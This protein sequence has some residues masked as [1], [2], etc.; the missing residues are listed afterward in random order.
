[1]IPNT[2][3]NKSQVQLDTNIHNEYPLSR[4]FIRRRINAHF[5]PGSGTPFKSLIS[6]RFYINKLFP[7]DFT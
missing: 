4:K 6:I 5:K 3:K 1:M 7:H 2:Y